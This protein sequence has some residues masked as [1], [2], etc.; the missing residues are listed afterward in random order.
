MTQILG[1]EFYKPDFGKTVSS[2]YF[3]EMGL[4]K[5]DEKNTEVLLLPSDEFHHKP[6]KNFPDG[7]YP[8]ILLVI[9]GSVLIKTAIFW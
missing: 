3:H 9:Y 7:T 4:M 5:Y 8:K 2:E 1:K 6:R